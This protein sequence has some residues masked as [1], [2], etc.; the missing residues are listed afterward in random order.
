MQ[1]QSQLPKV[2]ARL[3]LVLLESRLGSGSFFSENESL[4]S[5]SITKSL[6]SASFTSLVYN[7]EGD[8]GGW[9]YTN[10]DDTGG[11]GVY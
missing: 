4:C 2:S 7:N 8:T 6:G 9:G 11:V 3:G 5:A 10:E 1:S